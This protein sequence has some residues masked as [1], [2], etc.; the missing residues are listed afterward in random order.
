[1]RELKKIIMTTAKEHQYLSPFTCHSL[2][3]NEE[4]VPQQTARND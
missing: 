2:I 1:M 3:P 4:L